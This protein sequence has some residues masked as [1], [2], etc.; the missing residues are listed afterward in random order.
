MA[1][2]GCAQNVHTADAKRGGYEE[3]EDTIRRSTSG[4]G[5]KRK[6]NVK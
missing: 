4:G 6:T 3:A 5:G 2:V 1:T